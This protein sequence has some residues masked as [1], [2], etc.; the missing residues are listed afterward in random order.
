MDLKELYDKL[1]DYMG[2][3]II[4]KDGLEIIVNK[5]SLDL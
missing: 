5:K 2:K 4:L 1:K 3:E